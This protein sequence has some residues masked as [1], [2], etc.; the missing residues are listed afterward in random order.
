MYPKFKQILFALIAPVLFTGMANA[1]QASQFSI[2][3]AVEYAK[4]NNLAQKTKKLDEN[5]AQKKVTE[6][7]ALGLPQINAGVSYTNNI[8]IATQRLPNFINDALPPG[9]PKGPEFI[10]AQFGVAH[11][12]T[13]NAQLNQLI[14]DGTYFLG[15]KAAQEFVKIS[16]LLTQQ[17][18]TDLELNTI[19]SYYSVLMA[20]KR[21]VLMENS[22]RSLD[23]TLFNMRAMAKEGFVEMVD[24]A[25]I[26]YSLSNLKIQKAR[27]E[28]QRKIMLNYLKLQMGYPINQ[29]IELTESTESLEK[30]IKVSD[31]AGNGNVAARAEYKILDQQV[32]LGLLDVKR[33][34]MG[35]VPTLNGFLQHQQNTFASKGNLNQLG[36]PFFPGTTWGISLNIPIFSGFRQASLIKQADLRL[37][38]YKLN[39]DQFSQAYENEVFTARTN[40]LRAVENLDLQKKNVELAKE[41]KRIAKIKLQEGLGTSLEYTTAETEN[42]TAEASLV[43]ALYELM[44]AELDYRKATGAKIID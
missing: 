42:N 12:L 31:V 1:Q 40:Y 33:Y 21:L 5:I 27:L 23:S 11:S 24:T 17:S 18:E 38:Q 25:R 30:A 3:Q 15:L 44:V 22:L 9:S 6:I 37:Q 19:K 20:D 26:S 32:K 2:K 43:I 29:P 7:L 28:D 16:E 34:K 4:K 39:V 41:I 10:D 14:F 36:D 8:Q 35:Y 13:A